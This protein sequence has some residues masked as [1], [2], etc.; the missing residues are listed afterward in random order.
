MELLDWNVGLDGA[1]A[2]LSAFETCGWVEI[3]GIMA[4][5]VVSIFFADSLVS[6]WLGL[7]LFDFAFSSAFF[8]FSSRE[9][10][11]LFNFFARDVI[12][13]FVVE[14][15]GNKNIGNGATHM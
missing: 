7:F 5:S 1:V 13:A 9:M 2:A 15:A 3:V 8:P 14:S 11:V 6:W 10:N 12:R 4:C